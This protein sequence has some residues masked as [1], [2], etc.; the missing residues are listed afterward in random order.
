[1]GPFPS[2]CNNRD[3]LVMVDYGFKSVETIPTLTSD[4]KTVIRL[5]KRVIFPRFGIPKAVISDS[6]SHF[7][8]WQFE[9]PHR[10]YGIIHEVA[11]LHHPQT[12]RQVKTS[13]GEIKSILKKIVS[14]TRKD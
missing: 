1:M 6:G 4:S 9:N 5:F 13:N 8:E 11:M 10:K 3:K 2:S 7:I 14:G 12:N